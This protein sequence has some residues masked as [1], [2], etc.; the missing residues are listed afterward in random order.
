MVRPRKRRAWHS[1]YE[2]AFDKVGDRAHRRGCAPSSARR[3]CDRSAAHRIEEA[4][5]YSGAGIKS[6]KSFSQKRVNQSMLR[7]ITKGG[8]PFN[9][10]RRYVFNKIALS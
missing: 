5:S 10:K 8:M 2:A 9:H 1:A 4:V 7:F 6:R 3:Y